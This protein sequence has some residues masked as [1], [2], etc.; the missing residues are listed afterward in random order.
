MHEYVIITEVVRCVDSSSIFRCVNNLNRILSLK[1]SEVSKHNFSGSL[2]WTRSRKLLWTHIYRWIKHSVS[3][4]LR[5]HLRSNSTVSSELRWSE[6]RIE[7]KTLRMSVTY[8]SR[9]ESDFPWCAPDPKDTKSARCKTCNKC[10]RI[11]TMGKA[12]FTSHENGKAHKLRSSEKGSM[13]P[14]N[15]LLVK[16]E[17]RKYLW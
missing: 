17:F 15:Q 12:A 9:Y 14:L 1:K 5:L 3:W 16:S 8:S 11:D 7:S 2:T 13:T 10:F 4:L 6:K